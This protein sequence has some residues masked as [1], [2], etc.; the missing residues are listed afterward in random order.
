MGGL[1][2]SGRTTHEQGA[3]DGR[4]RTGGR[5]GG[6]TGSDWKEQGRIEGER[7]RTR[8]NGVGL[9]GNRVKLGGN[10]VGL[11][12]NKVGLGGNGVGLGGWGRTGW[13]TRSDWMENGVGLDGERG[14]TGWGTGPKP[15]LYEIRH[16]DLCIRLL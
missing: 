9:G 1:A 13:R 16:F 2:S 6:G 11:G 4:G 8:G 10:G 12:G 5:T 7:G 3:R 15:G 14:R